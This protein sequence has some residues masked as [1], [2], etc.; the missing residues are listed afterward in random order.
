VFSGGDE[1]TLSRAG[2]GVVESRQEGRISSPNGWKFQGAH[3]RQ[4]IAG[5][6]LAALE[7]ALEKRL[8]DLSGTRLTSPR[9]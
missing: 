9:L 7:R 8:W 3:D 5:E 2:L 1:K 4:E 6:T